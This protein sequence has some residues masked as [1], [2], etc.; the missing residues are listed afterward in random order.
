VTFAELKA[1]LDALTPEQLAFDVTWSGDERGGPVSALW[2]ADEDWLVD[3]YG[4]IRRSEFEKDDLE[5]A[6]TA[7]VCVPLGMPQLM[8]DL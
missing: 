2:I 5:A 4:P 7:R 8:V 6:S 3:D 1:Q